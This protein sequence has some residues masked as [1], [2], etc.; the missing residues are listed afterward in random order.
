MTKL[1]FQSILTHRRS[2]LRAHDKLESHVS[3]QFDH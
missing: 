3:K 2:T 1:T